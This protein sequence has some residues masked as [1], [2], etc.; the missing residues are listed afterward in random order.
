M[1]VDA[2]GGVWRYAMDLCRALNDARVRVLLVG[3]GPPPGT[4]QGAEAASLP[5]TRLQWL[6]APLDWM[7]P[8]AAA[9]VGVPDEL[10]ALAARAGVDLLH[11]NLPSQAAGLRTERPVLIVSHSCLPSWWAAMRGTAL[12]AEW[13][14]QWRL[15]AAGLARAEAVVA[16]SASHAAALRATYA[17]EGRIRVVPNAAAVT[18]GAGPRELL[19][20]AAARWWDEA[21]G[22]ALLD[23]AAAR[24]PWPVQAAGALRGDN[25]AAFTFHHA[26]ALGPLPAEDLRNRMRRAA[27]FASPSRYE[28]F[29]LAA[30]EAAQAGAAL[31]LA[32]IPTYREIWDGAAEFAADAGCLAA[33]LH[34][35]ASDPALLHRRAAQ[36]RERAARFTPDRQLAALLA[37]YAAAAAAACPAE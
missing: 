32:E 25:G 7:A 12:P 15:N 23:E 11:L 18:P 2:V 33:A 29:G 1:T 22:G 28:P 20:L 31:V 14:W 26:T 30:L 36:A 21:K 24:S 13:A 19:V 16:P 3:L 37:A 5:G 6:D 8:D 35:L 17:P 10:A 34:R 27:V 4:A 9:L